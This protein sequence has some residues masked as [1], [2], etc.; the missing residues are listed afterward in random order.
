MKKYPLLVFTVCL[1]LV[2]YTIKRMITFFIPIVLI[3]LV[4]VILAK[5][6]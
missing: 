6:L 1:P 4:I 3:L 2:S 5:V